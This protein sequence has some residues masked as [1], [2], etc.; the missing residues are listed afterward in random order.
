MELFRLYRRQYGDPLSGQ[1]AAIR[2][3]RWNSPGTALVY[4]A[5]NRSLAMAEV[6]VHLSLAT[7]P[8]DYEMAV[9]YLPE[10]LA[11]GRLQP[12]AL[13]PN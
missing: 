10:Q 1:G 11:I 2:G 8:Q 7:L 9:L 12:Q 6:L 3:G 13:P 4:T 5:A